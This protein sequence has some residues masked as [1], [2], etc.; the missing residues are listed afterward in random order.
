LA[1]KQQLL[2]H[3]MVPP[4]PQSFKLVSDTRF[5]SPA[6]SPKRCESILVGG[7]FTSLPSFFVGLDTF[8]SLRSVTDTLC[9]TYVGVSER[10]ISARPSVS[11]HYVGDFFYCSEFESLTFFFYC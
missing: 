7:F 4:S 3:E 6:T 9:S 1:Y 11:F 5:S 2:G 8:E 10:V